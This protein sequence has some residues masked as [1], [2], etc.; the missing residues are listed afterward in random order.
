MGSSEREARARALQG[1][2]ETHAAAAAMGK[3]MSMRVRESDDQCAVGHRS[4]RLQVLSNAPTEQFKKVDGGANACASNMRRAAACIHAASGIMHA[5]SAS[6]HGIQ[7]Q[8][9]IGRVVFDFFSQCQSYDSQRDSSRH[10]R[11]AMRTE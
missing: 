9:V 10:A 7:V 2:T 4:C 6:R 3:A 1:D 5:A 8:W 11:H